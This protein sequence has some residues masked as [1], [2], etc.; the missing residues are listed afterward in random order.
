MEICV[1]ARW[2]NSNRTSRRHCYQWTKNISSMEPIITILIALGIASTAT[3][4]A[5]R[6]L[7]IEVNP[8][9][10]S[11]TVTAKRQEVQNEELQRN[12][13]CCLCW[14]VI[15]YSPTCFGSMQFKRSV[16]HVSSQC[17][18]LRNQQSPVSSQCGVDWL[19]GYSQTLP[20]PKIWRYV[21]LFIVLKSCMDY[22]RSKLKLMPEQ[23]TP[24]SS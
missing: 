18:I 14:R 2:D 16:I 4:M 23:Y 19:W 7:D 5:V 9:A 1:Q 22:G 24:W 13:N 6:T 21:Q 20:H 12:R 8:S 11:A 10:H 17:A 15:A 3:V